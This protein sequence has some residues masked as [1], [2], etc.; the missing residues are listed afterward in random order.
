[1]A[2]GDARPIRILSEDLTLYRGE[3]GQ[4]YL[5][6]GRCAHRQTLLYVG[7][8]EGEQIRCMYHGWKYDGTGQCVE[9]PAEADNGLPRVKVPGY[10]A[11]DYCGLVF[12]YLADGPAA[13]FDLPRKEVFEEPGRLLFPRQEIWNCNWFQGVENSLDAVHVSFV[14]RAGKVG[15]FGEAVKATI[16][17]LEYTET[18]AGIRQVATRGPNNVRISNWTFPNHNNINQPGLTKDDPWI[19]I[20]SWVVPL[21]DE[22]TARVS[23]WTVPSTTAEA[24]ERIARYFDQRGEY[25]PADNHHLLF[26]KKQYPDDPIVQLTSAQDYVAQLGQGTITDRTKELLGRSDA[27]IVFLRK[28]FLRELA[29]IRDGRPTKRWRK[30]EGRVELPRQA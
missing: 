23:L 22:H 15:T 11:R 24:D 19:D 26:G 16:P 25:N 2:P 6:S 10:P 14:H 29:A 21:D 17:K 28:I 1:V 20:G 8:V 13:E 27:G 3:S 12:A 7:T 18:E 4:P 5:V 9:R 30:L